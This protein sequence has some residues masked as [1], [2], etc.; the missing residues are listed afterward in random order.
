MMGPIVRI[1]V[2][3]GLFAV[4]PSMAWAE[5]PPSANPP[6]Q[7]ILV[8]RNGQIL[9]GRIVQSEGLYTVYLSDGQ[10]RVKAA[11][12]DL[13]CN[14]M[15]D[16]YQRKRAVIQ[17][18]NVSHHLELAQWCLRH[19]L[20]GHASAELAD[21]TAADPQ[22]PM[23][24][25]LKNR[26]KMA[27]EP[28]DA[29][30]SPATKPMPVAGP[31]NEELDR[32]VRGLP[33]GAV[34]MFTQSVQPVLMNHCTS[35]GCHGFQSQTNLRLVRIPT[36][37]AATKRIT[38]RNLASVLQFIDRE[39]PMSSKLL[40][41]PCN[42]HGTAQHAIFNEREEAQFERLAAWAYQVAN[43]QGRDVPDTVLPEEQTV[44]ADPRFPQKTPRV[45]SQESRKGRPLTAS[46]R[47]PPAK[48]PGMRDPAP[49]PSDVAPASFDSPADP[50]DPEIFNRKFAP[51][52]P[53]E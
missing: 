26:L 43:R 50:M 15:E 25:V 48:R 18:G 10:I 2:A 39:N 16:G 9:E 6:D 31:S 24:G 29:E 21:A 37:K 36:G 35:S 19:R 13:I 7:R 51:Q 32:M 52:K 40:K 30:D 5:N 17:L 14:N 20:W 45:L 12:V 34:E 3:V 4:I 41:I 23:I 53:Q 49:P 22:N 47:T 46:N 38:Q 8:L 27:T 44:K 33:H 1:A 11:D 42:P 28:Q